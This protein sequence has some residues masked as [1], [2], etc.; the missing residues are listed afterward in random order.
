MILNKP[1]F[2]DKNQI[3]IW[4]ILLMPITII[5]IIFNYFKFKKYKKLNF[6]IPII[7]VGNIYIGGTGK[8]PLAIEIYKILKSLNKKPA[9]IRKFYQNHNDEHSMLRKFGK[10]FLNKERKIAINKLIKNNKNIAILDD[11]LQDNKINFDLSIA[12]FNQKQWIGNGQVIPSGPLR[13]N[14]K[15]LKKYDHVF[16]NGSS[17]KNNVFEKKLYSF[18]PKVKI[19]YSYYKFTNLA[20]LKKKKIIAFAGIGNPINFFDLLK[21]SKLNVIKTFNFPDHY[22]YTKKDISALVN[23]SKKL[24]A[25]L[26]TTEKDYFRLNYKQKIGINYIRIKLIIKNKKQLIKEINKII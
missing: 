5:I 13:E 24:D 20:H 6:S 14:L 11:G 22:N 23:E 18:N 3:S 19:F 25:I 4:S 8:T 2:W 17:K 15:A 26:L 10:L 16:I 7:C 9:F 12:C 1:K 21:K